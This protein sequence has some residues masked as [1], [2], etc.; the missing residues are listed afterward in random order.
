MVCVP[1]QGTPAAKMN[2]FSVL[3]TFLIWGMMSPVPTPLPAFLVPR[4]GHPKSSI[5]LTHPFLLPYPPTYAPVSPPISVH[6]PTVMLTPTPLPGTEQL[7]TPSGEAARSS[8][9]HLLGPPSDLLGS[10]SLGSSSFWD[11]ICSPPAWPPRSCF[12]S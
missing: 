3:T 2:H 7:E 4:E 6:L 1:P 5:S 9:H 12:F 10:L 8:N 11:L